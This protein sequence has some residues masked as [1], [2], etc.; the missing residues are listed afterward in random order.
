MRS[1]SALE[2]NSVDF[3]F[4]KDMER[5]LQL[6]LKIRLVYCVYC[7]VEVNSRQYLQCSYFWKSSVGRK[8][9]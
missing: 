2:G 1:A 7:K 8:S 5:M 9:H 6:F 3:V 4:Q